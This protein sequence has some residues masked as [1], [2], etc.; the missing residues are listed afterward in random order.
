MKT[1]AIPRAREEGRGASSAV[2]YGSLL[3][4]SFVCAL[5][6]IAPRTK[7]MK[8]TTKTLRRAIGGAALAAILVTAASAQSPSWPT[9]PAPAPQAERPAAPQAKCANS[10]DDERQVDLTGSLVV[11]AVRLSDAIREFGR[12]QDQGRSLSCTTAARVE[13]ALG[14]PARATLRGAWSER[15]TPRSMTGRGEVHCLERRW[16]RYPPLRRPNAR[17]TRCRQIVARTR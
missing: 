15:V 12:N 8:L 1:G 4:C 3:K 10:G 17:Q 6:S 11:K 7:Q 13:M 5:L 9:P 14:G 16:R 2:E